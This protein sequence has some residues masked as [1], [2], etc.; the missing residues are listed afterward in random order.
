[1]VAVVGDVCVTVPVPGT[2]HRDGRPAVKISCAATTSG[3][4]RHHDDA[5]LLAIGRRLTT[6]TSWE[7]EEGAA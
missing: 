3:T 7:T 2:V 4:A 1:M 6:P 5:N